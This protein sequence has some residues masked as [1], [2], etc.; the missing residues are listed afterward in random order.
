MAFGR[1]DQRES[2]YSNPDDPELKEIYPRNAPTYGFNKLRERITQTWSAD[3]Q[4]TLDLENFYSRKFWVPELRA[5]LRLRTA[6]RVL[7]GWGWIRALGVVQFPP[8]IPIG[9]VGEYG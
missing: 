7:A 3:L 8:S 1:R 6:R 9:N 4:G 5:V 2:Y